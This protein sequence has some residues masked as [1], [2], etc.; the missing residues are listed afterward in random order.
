MDY[1]ILRYQGFGNYL[2]TWQFSWYFYP[3][4]LRNSK[5]KACWPYHFLK[6]PNRIF[7]VHLNI[8]PKLCLSFA[9]ICRKYKKWAIFDILM[10]I[11]L[12]VSI[13]SRQM[14]PFFSCI[15]WALSVGIFHFC[16]GRTQNSALWDFPIYIMFWS[17][18]CTFTCQSWHFQAC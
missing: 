2:L 14:I 7:Q 18:K 10:T 13:I 11:T 6:E 9:A 3:R 1:R 8:I 16:I 12:G 15:L 17:V 5:S 4:Y